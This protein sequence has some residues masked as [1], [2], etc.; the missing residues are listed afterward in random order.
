MIRTNENPYYWVAIVINIIF[1]G[2]VIF[3]E[4]KEFMLLFKK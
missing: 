4:R 2:T 3:K 1:L